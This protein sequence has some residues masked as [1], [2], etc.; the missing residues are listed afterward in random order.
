MLAS[1]AFLSDAVAHA[2][3]TY[4]EDHRPADPTSLPGT[5]LPGTQPSP[6]I[7]EG[8]AGTER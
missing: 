8:P 5:D 2:D 6:S 7:P 3:L 1:R 4:A